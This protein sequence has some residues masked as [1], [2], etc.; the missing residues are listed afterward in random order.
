MLT[1]TSNPFL[2]PDYPLYF[3][4]LQFTTQTV[5]FDKVA[6][7]RYLTKDF[8]NGLGSEV[9]PSWRSRNTDIFQQ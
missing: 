8:N 1:Y 2:F 6:R 4:I 7:D 5:I 9:R 3:F